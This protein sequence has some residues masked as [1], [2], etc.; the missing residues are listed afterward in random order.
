MKNVYYAVI[1]STIG[2]TICATPTLRKLYQT[3]QRKINLV[4]Q[5]DVKSVW[6][7]NPYINKLYT[8]QEFKEEFKGGLLGI[9]YHESY[10]LPGLHNQFGMQRKF[11]MVDLR[12]VHANDI[13]IQLQP[14]EMTC[15]F[16][17][18]E[19]SG[20]CKLPKDYVVIHPSTNWPNRTW[21]QEKWQKL[22]DFLSERNIYTVVI[23]KNMVQIEPY[24]IT[25]KYFKPLDNLYGVD[26]TNK[27]DL[28]DSWHLLNNA[29]MV[30]TVDTGILHLAGTTDTF[31]VQLGSAKNPKLVA[32]YRNGSQ[33]YKYTYVKG[34]CD[35]FCT[36][37]LRYSAKERD[38]IN[39]IPILVGCLENK[40][41]FECHS[42]TDDVIKTI[43]Y[44][45]DN[46]IV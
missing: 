20:V 24:V 8:F 3:Y 10:V 14:E 21:P 37:N 2:D 7:N 43:S 23:G 6:I 29:K 27:T 45:F 39:Q 30:I 11:N 42:S 36:S 9:N 16:Y 31:I 12:Q 15:E 38:D 13:G 19:F 5:P 26:L 34:N 40:P 1:S 4:T 44:L 22:V 28:S 46:K 17:A 32:P 18:N 35:L 25:E 33:N 41:T